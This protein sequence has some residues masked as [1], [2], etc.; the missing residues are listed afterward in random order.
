[1]ERSRGVYRAAWE[2]SGLPTQVFRAGMLTE[3]G[4]E[5]EVPTEEPRAEPRCHDPSMAE[6]STRS[7]LHRAERV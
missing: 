3:D 1:M 7:L 4:V 5:G 2:R 6:Q